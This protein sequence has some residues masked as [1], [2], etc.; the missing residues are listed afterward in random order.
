MAP[1]DKD[2]CYDVATWQELSD[3]GLIYKINKEI[4]HPVGLALSWD[5]DLNTS[6]GAI[7]SPDGEWE[8]DDDSIAKEEEKLNKFYAEHHAN[9]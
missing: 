4:L 6:F 9:I 7:K 8:Y 3:A 2:V 5:P 1:Y